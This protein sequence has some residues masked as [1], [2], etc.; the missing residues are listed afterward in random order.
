MQSTNIFDEY[1]RHIGFGSY[2]NA[3]DM[4]NIHMT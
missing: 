3:N 1:F 2:F 4:S